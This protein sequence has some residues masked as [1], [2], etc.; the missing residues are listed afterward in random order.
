MALVEELRGFERAPKRLLISTDNQ[1]LG[2]ITTRGTS[3]RAEIYDIE[4]FRVTNR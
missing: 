3:E 4:A 1:K 2:V